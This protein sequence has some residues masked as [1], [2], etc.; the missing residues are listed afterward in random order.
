MSVYKV[1]I[2]INQA[3]DADIGINAEVIYWTNSHQINVSPTTGTVH[4]PDNER[5][6]ADRTQVT[7][8]A[9]DRLGDGLTGELDLLVSYKT[10]T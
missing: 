4:L 9:T 10:K 7:V 8:Y 2:L 5:N 3:S 6:L 1:I